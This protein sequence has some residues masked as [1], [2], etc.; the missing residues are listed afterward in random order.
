CLPTAYIPGWKTDYRTLVE[1]VSTRLTPQDGLIISGPDKNVACVI[2]GA[3]QHY[4]RQTPA[5][6]AV[7]TA[8]PNPQVLSRMQ[9]CPHVWIIWTHFDKP[10]S[11]EFPTFQVEDRGNI[12][13]FAEILR[14]RF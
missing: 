9:Q 5:A 14:G 4:L 10:A 12:P 11:Q 2:F 13:Y 1:S 3:F 6:S 8:P 7:V